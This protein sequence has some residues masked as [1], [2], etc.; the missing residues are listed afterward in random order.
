MGG[1]T[2]CGEDM[3]H[4]E[5]H[6]QARASKGAREEAH[7]R[8][9]R[10]I[11][12]C[13]RGCGKCS[14]AAPPPPTTKDL[15]GYFNNL[16]AVATNKKAVLDQLVANN[17]TLTTTNAEMADAIKSLQVNVQMLRQEVSGFKLLLANG[18]RR[19]GG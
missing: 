12:Q 18:R 3:G 17:A 2:A 6:V 19:D 9:A 11:W 5:G 13:S 14:E 16:A 4:M 15:A 8:W 7:C 10:S 1:F